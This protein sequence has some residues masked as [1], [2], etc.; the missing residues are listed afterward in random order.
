MLAPSTV[1]CS[2]TRCG[3]S[4]RTPGVGWGV[5]TVTDAPILRAIASFDATTRACDPAP[6]V[7][8]AVRARS[9]WRRVVMDPLFFGA[10]RAFA[11]TSGLGE[12]ARTGRWLASPD[13]AVSPRGPGALLLSV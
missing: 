13:V 10:V 8:R 5:P 9:S 6:A 11:F 1:P 12:L 7:F 2:S 3:W 4:A